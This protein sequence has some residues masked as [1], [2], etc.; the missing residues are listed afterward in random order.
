MV[1]LRK[2]KLIPPAP[3]SITRIVESPPL[4]ILFK[5]LKNK[6]KMRKLKNNMKNDVPNI[7]S[8]LHI[9]DPSL[10]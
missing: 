1:F 2:L 6:M 5:K 4:L 9:S 3:P 8:H 10:L 7:P